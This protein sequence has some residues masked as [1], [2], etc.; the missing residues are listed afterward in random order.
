MTPAKQRALTI[1][2]ITLGIVIVGFFGI[3]A[4]HAF[5]EFTG[6]RPH[7]FP[8]P[9]SQPAQTDVSLIRDWMT[10]GYISEAYRLPRNLLYE[11]VNIP[12][13]GNEHKSLKQLND[14]YFP[15]TAGVVLAKVKAAVLANEPAPTASSPNTA[16]SPATPMPTIKP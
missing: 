2:L 11:A 3:R 14:E 6:H 16:M 7:H 5:R 13:K 15:Q 8:P 1:G 10:I 4:L 9:G 12:P